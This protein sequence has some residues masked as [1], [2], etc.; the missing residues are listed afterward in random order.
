MNVIVNVLHFGTTHSGSFS[1]VLHFYYHAVTVV[2][3][4]YFTSGDVTVNEGDGT[5]EVCLELSVP[6]STDLEVSVS[7][8]P[9][10]GEN[11]IIN[12]S[13]LCFLKQPAEMMIS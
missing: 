11:G 7:S 6:L 5:A 3:E 13:F 12:C 2:A 4:L 10:T 9:G 1:L 8:N